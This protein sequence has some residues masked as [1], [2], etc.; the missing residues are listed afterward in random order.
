MSVLL[1]S[2]VAVPLHAQTDSSVAHAAVVQVRNES[3]VA[4]PSA[5]ARRGSTTRLMVG[6]LVG[7]SAGFIAAWGATPRDFR[8]ADGMS[9][10]D[11]FKGLALLSVSESVGMAIG[12]YAANHGQG[13]LVRAAAAS[14]GAG[15]LG[16]AIGIGAGK[17]IGNGAYV[18]V[19]LV[20]IPI[21]IVALR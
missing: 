2:L 3:H 1:V 5:E 10:A 14:F 15:I 12:T 20:Q 16:L 21:T 19:P 18:A 17:S 4:L 9:T 6:G 13:H 11:L 7:G 8:N